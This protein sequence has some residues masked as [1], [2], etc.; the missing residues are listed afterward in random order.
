MCLIFPVILVYVDITPFELGTVCIPFMVLSLACP[1]TK[2][3]YTPKQFHQLQSQM[4]PSGPCPWQ[5]CWSGGTSGFSFLCYCKKRLSILN[6]SSTL[7]S[8]APLS[9]FGGWSVQAKSEQRRMQAERE[10]KEASG[11]V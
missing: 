8:N 1:K 3:L 6:W 7:H 9:R 2:I 5:N 10:M 11:G 4:P